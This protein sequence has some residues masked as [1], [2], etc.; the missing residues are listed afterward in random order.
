MKKCFLILV[1]V[2]GFSSLAGAQKFSVGGG[3]T[4]QFQSGLTSQFQT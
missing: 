2:L 3:L 1:V 4:S